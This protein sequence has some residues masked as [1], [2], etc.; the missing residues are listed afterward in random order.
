MCFVEFS[1]A[2]IAFVINIRVVNY[3]ADTYVGLLLAIYDIVPVF[4]RHMDDDSS[5]LD[6]HQSVIILRST[7]A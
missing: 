7:K 2:Y 1:A 4:A 6:N 5:L 3:S